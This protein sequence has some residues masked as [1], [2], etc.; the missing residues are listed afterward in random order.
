MSC[1]IGIYCIF[2]IDSYTQ[3]VTP[4][5]TLLY[6]IC[7]YVG[8]IH[9]LA[10]HAVACFLTR[11]VRVYYVLYADWVCACVYYMYC[12]QT[13]YVRMYCVLY[14]EHVYC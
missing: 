2:S 10:R 3:S 11:Y 4:C 7:G 8:W 5:H 13:R 14:A 6:H 9:H 1:Y 12:M